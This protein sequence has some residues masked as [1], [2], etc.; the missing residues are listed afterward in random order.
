QGHQEPEPR[1]LRWTDP[2]LDTEDAARAR[3][4]VADSGGQTPRPGGEHPGSEQRHQ[5]AEAPRAPHQTALAEGAVEPQILARRAI[6]RRK[7]EDDHDPEAGQDEPLEEQL[8]RARSIKI[9]LALKGDLGN[10]SR[11]G[12]ISRRR[13]AALSILDEHGA[14]PPAEGCARQ[15]AKQAAA[16]RTSPG[17]A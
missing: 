14:A 10:Q 15:P 1:R 5:D 13:P 9:Q 2:S 4:A 3:L 12:R 17:D 6:V 11:L 8:A 16:R 7:E